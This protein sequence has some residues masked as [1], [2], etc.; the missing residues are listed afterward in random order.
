[1]SSKIRT[2]IKSAIRLLQEGQLVAIPT[3][4]VYGLGGDATRDDVIAR[5]FAAKGRPQFNPLIIHVSGIGGAEK[6]VDINSKA[7]KLIE[8]FWP[9][10]LTLVLP[11]KSDAKISLLAASGLPTL[12]VRA[13]NHAMTRE[14]LAALPFPLAAPSANP[15]GHLS[16]TLPRHVE[17]L[18]GQVAMILDGGPCEIGL[19]STV[20]DLS[21]AKPRILRA[22]FVTKEEIESLIGPVTA[23]QDGDQIKSPGMMLKHY[24]P[25]TPL[26]L[27]IDQPKNNEG[28]LAFGKNIPSGFKAV[29][30]LSESGNLIE[31]AANL[32]AHLHELDQMNLNSIAAM[33]APNEGLGIAINDRLKRAA[34]K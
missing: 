5:I 31:A 27:T 1:M 21:E 10:P 22:G 12:A 19:E 28:L 9:G 25:K 33:K 6:L 4:T 23:A 16:P 24:A 29:K 11:R 30:N 14:L 13:P 26:R 32:F 8:K 2:D 15:S 34:E 18:G 20:L 17:K 7:Q 3:E